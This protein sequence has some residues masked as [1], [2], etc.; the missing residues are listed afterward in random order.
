SFKPKLE[1]L[2]SKEGGIETKSQAPKQ[3]EE[4][5]V[6]EIL[7]E[8]EVDPDEAYK[9]K[10]IVPVHYDGGMYIKEFYILILLEKSQKQRMKEKAKIEKK[11]QKT[12]VIKEITEIIGDAPEEAE[13]IGA[14]KKAKDEKFAKE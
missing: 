4:E 1:N 8:E 3:I 7:S 6:E 14:I 13:S 11:I 12:K 5:I 9:V 10:M 2:V